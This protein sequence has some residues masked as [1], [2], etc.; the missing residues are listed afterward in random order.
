MHRWA[1][2]HITTKSSAALLVTDQRAATWN[3]RQRTSQAHLDTRA[4]P[5]VVSR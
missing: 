3:M 2:L 5:W 4:G 1:M